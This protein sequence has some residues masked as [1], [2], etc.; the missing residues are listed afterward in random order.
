MQVLDWN[1]F[2]AQVKMALQGGS[3]PD[4]LQT[5]GCPQGRRRPLP[6]GRRGA[7]PGNPRPL[8]RRLRPGRRDGRSAVRHSMRLLDPRADPQREASPTPTPTPT[9]RRRAGTTSN[10]TRSTARRRT[11]AWS[12]SRGR[13]VLRRRSADASSGGS[14]ATAAATPTPTVS[15]PSTATPT[16]KRSNGRVPTSLSP[17]A[18][19][20]VPPPPTANA[21]WCPGS[22]PDR[23]VR[24][25]PTQLHLVPRKN[26]PLCQPP[27][28]PAP[29]PRSPP[30][31]PF[32]VR[33]SC[34]RCRA[35]RR[36]APTR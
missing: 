33:P 30:S 25:L 28:P 3:T 6:E 36:P 10:R 22:P 23:S 34:R 17:A 19:T 14:S 35:I 16:S 15:A 5:G 26:A 9:S 2:D 29:R 21:T 20:A 18:P 4:V 31:P 32:G 27:G 8:R 11:P 13:S 1:D 24:P 12:R 7:V